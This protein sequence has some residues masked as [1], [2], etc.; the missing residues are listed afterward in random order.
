M[1]IASKNL[2]EQNK[3]FAPRPSLIGFLG[4]IDVVRYRPHS[5]ERANGYWFSIIHRAT[6]RT[7][8]LQQNLLISP[9]SRPSRSL[10]SYKFAFSMYGSDQILGS[11]FRWKR[12]CQTR[13]LLKTALF[14][15][16]RKFEQIIVV[17]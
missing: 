11:L 13:E 3:S 17:C 15:H 5:S 10:S 4:A 12:D 16:A 8:L 9:S 7:R 6:S 2:I 1:K 14:V